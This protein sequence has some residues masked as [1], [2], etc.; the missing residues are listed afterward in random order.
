MPDNDRQL[1]SDF[2]TG[3]QT[4]KQNEIATAINRGQRQM[5]CLFMET[6]SPS[7]YCDKDQERP[8]AKETN[9]GEDRKERRSIG[10][11]KNPHHNG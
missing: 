6:Y 8:Q 7:A 1:V 3:A 10:Q 9:H 11:G 2:L 5:R 4:W